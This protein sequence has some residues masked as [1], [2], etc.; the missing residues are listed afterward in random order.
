MIKSPL[1]PDRIR[2][3]L[4]VEA[5]L[6]DG[7]SMPFF[8]LFIGLAAAVE[9]FVPGSWL[10]Y[11]VEQIGYGLLV[12]IAIGWVGGWLLGGAGKRGWIDETRVMMEIL[13]SFKRAGA[14]LILTYHAMDAAKELN[15]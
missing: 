1:V 12:G 4:G 15:K 10:I 5:G 6:N 9:S 8:S 14:D 7:L 11:S 13:T 3:A 2:Q